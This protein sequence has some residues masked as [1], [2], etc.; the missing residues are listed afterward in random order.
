MSVIVRDTYGKIMLLCKGADSIILPRL[1]EGT[2]P[3]L[4]VTQ[5]FVDKY[6]EEGLRTLLLAQKVLDE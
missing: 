4:S 6:A 5:G 3:A 1:N 2:S